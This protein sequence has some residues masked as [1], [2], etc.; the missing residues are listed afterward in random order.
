[1]TAQALRPA[2]AGGTSTRGLYGSDTSAS[3]VRSAAAELVGTAILVFAGTAVATAAILARPTAGAAYD[4]LAVGLAFGLALT[5]LVA[6]LGH[7]SGCHLNP[8][9]TISLTVTGRFPRSYAVPYLAAQIAGAA[10]GAAATWLAYGGPARRV[11][12]LAATY[13]AKG[14]GDVRALLVEALVTYV[15]VLVVISVATDD[16]VEPQI[17]PVAVGFALAAGVLIAGPITGGAVNPARALGP[18]I[19]AGDLHAFWLYVLGPIGGGVA[20]AMTYDRLLA[21]A[22]A[23]DADPND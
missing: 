11:A 12:H 3:V 7:V 16:R 1:M 2:A 14:V 22:D 20:A 15:L 9:V 23:P 18:M 21:A 19:M 6:A 13:P 8:A 10:V 4:S 5:A 17:A